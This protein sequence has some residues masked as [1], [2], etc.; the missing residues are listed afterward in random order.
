[1]LESTASGTE[2]LLRSQHHPPPLHRLRKSKIS[3]MVAAGLL[4]LVVLSVTL[5]VVFRPQSEKQV[6]FR[7]QHPAMARLAVA[8]FTFNISDPV[9]TKD[10]AAAA[11]G[12]LSP[13]HKAHVGFLGGQA[14]KT[15]PK[16]D[17][18]DELD[19]I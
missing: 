7:L 19:K 18:Y 14:N 13:R 17:D 15:A 3:M 9:Q 10:N 16:M 5:G 4:I 1:M 2:L 11:F 12:V 6:D 8:N